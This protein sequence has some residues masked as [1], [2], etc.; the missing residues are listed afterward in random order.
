MLHRKL[1][2][3]VVFGES[4]PLPTPRLVDRPQVC[5]LAQ[6]ILKKAQHTHNFFFQE[7]TVLVILS[8][9]IDLYW[10][11]ERESYYPGRAVLMIDAGTTL[12]MLKTPSLESK[13]FRSYFLTL[14]PTLVEDFRRN[15]AIVISTDTVDKPYRA[16]NTTENL[17]ETLLRVYR[18]IATP[19]VS[20][21]RLR[22]RL[23]DLLCGIAEQGGMFSMFSNSTVT[24]KVRA[25]VASAPDHFWTAPKIGERLAMSEA[26]LRRKLAKEKTRFEALLTD[27]R[28]HHALML[29]QTTALPIIHVAERSGY[30]SR[31]RFS[32]RFIKRFGYPPS[33]VR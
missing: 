22:Y 3:K 8:G 10:R 33:D 20:D 19:T 5:S 17:Q 9:Q 31:S 21:E 28:M 14:A 27:V 18:D 12:D 2:S 29:L 32:Q 30:K 24:A 25:L 4:E 16:V 11:G 13:Q 6:P 15:T 1:N 23:L 7:A 26:T